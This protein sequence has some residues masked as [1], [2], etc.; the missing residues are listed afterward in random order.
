MRQPTQESCQTSSRR[1]RML[2]YPVFVT[3]FRKPSHIGSPLRPPHWRRTILCLHTRNGGTNREPTVFASVR[4]RKR[5]RRSGSTLRRRGSSSIRKDRLMS[6]RP[7]FSRRVH[8]RSLWRV[9]G[10]C[11]KQTS[12]ERVVSPALA[13]GYV[14]NASSLT[15]R[16]QVCVIPAAV[17]C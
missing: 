13:T 14:I 16:K 4:S 17:T 1:G 15:R 5:G 10:C 9:L 6:R 3:R 7:V 2:R 8:V 11:S 12:K